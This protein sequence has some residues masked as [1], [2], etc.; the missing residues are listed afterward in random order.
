[1]VI[2]SR[3]RF[4]KRFETR[5]K[6]DDASA[7]YLQYPHVVPFQILERNRMEWNGM[8]WNGMEWNG[9]EGN[10]MEWNGMEWN[11]MER[12]NTE[13]HRIE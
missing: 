11:G 2:G 6:A 13:R 7:L 10:G 9:M 1:M 12:N 8:E 3:C 4:S 5:V